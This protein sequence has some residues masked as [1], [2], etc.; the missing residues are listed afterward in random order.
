MPDKQI[1]SYAAAGGV[2]VDPDVERILVLVVSRSCTPAGVPEARLPKGHIEAGEGRAQAALREVMEETG[3]MGVQ[4][5]A[6]LGHL[7]VEFD[8]GDRHVVRDESYFLMQI[9][10]HDGW[11]DPE[12]KFERHWLTWDEAIERLTY[13]PEREWVRRARRAWRRVGHHPAIE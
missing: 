7:A 11:G 9:T 4:V 10:S 6:D 8:H 13:A 1:R 5:L 3:L 2:V 12:A